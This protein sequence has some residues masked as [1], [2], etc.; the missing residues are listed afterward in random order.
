M[1]GTVKP[2]PLEREPLQSP[3]VGS[4]EE[5]PAT[6]GAACEE[7]ARGRR[8]VLECLSAENNSGSSGLTAA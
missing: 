8:E 6:A 5:S 7:R 4:I 3:E 1:V 2:D